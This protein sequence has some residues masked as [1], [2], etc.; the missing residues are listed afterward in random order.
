MIGQPPFLSPLLPRDGDDHDAHGVLA[1]IVEDPAVEEDVED[2]RVDDDDEVEEGEGET[3]RRSR[4]GSPICDAPKGRNSAR[5]I[6]QSWVKIAIFDLDLQD[7]L[8]DL[9]LF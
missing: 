3:T 2:E 8:I 5:R 4:I 6:D 9:D 1:H 7:L